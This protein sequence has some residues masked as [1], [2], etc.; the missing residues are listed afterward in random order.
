MQYQHAYHLEDGR[1]EFIPFTVPRLGKFD[2]SEF[3]EFP[4]R[5]GWCVHRLDRH[6]HKSRC[7]PGVCVAVNTGQPHCYG[8]NTPSISRVGG[9]NATCSMKLA[10][11][12]TWLFFGALAEAHAVCNLPIIP[13]DFSADVFDTARRNGLPMRLYF[14]SKESGHAGSRALKEKLYAIIRQIQLMITRA[15]DWEDEHDYTL[16]Q[17][18][19]L[20][21]IQIL[22]RM[23][24]LALLCHS[25]SPFLDLEDD[26]SLSVADPVADW[27]PEGQMSMMK[28]TANRLLEKGWCRSELWQILQSFDVSTAAYYLDRPYAIQGHDSCTDT[29]CTAYQ[30]NESSYSTLHIDSSCS[31]AFIS[32]KPAELRD[33][34]A[35]NAIPKIAITDDLQLSIVDED[36]L[37]YIAFSH[38]W[39]DGLGNPSQNALPSCH[40]R[41]LRDLAVDLCSKFELVEKRK[42]MRVAIWM[43]TLC[44]PVAPEL[45]EY[46]KLAIRLLAQT[47]AEA[48]GVLV[49]DR[50]LCRFES[51]NASILELSIRL[52]CSGWLKR[53][54]TLQEASLTGQEAANERPGGALYIQMAEG[55]AHWHGHAKRFMYKPFSTSRPTPRKPSPLAVSV[56]EA[57]TDLVYGMHL[58]TAMEDRLPSVRTIQEPRFDTR[59]QKI[60][61]AVQNRSTSKPEDEPICMASLLALDLKQILSAKGVDERMMKFYRLLHEIPTAIVFAEFGLPDF[62]SRNIT[63][64]PYRWA[65]RSLLSL[66]RPMEINIALSAMRFAD[67]PLPLL[68]KCEDDGLHI[69]HPGFLFED[70]GPVTFARETALLDTGE[71]SLYRLSLAL[72]DSSPLTIGPVERC[73][74]IFKTDICSDVA[75]VALESERVLEAGM[76]FCVA[77]L[78]HGTVT[79]QSASELSGRDGSTGLQALRG[80]STKRDQQWCIT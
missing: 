52:M 19:V 72:S 32:V 15:S 39:A 60:V 23:L 51:G 71:G 34:L 28:F 70:M 49:I 73:A 77:I 37:V 8:L 17:C 9:G 6:C 26:L 10:F 74:L 27:K 20:F 40:I 11:L 29:T 50:E 21:S 64:A 55:P 13:D 75:I 54:W 47:Y 16:T 62:L 35:R 59:F 14:A 25:R 56:Q 68:G 24:S 57:K 5:A 45:K 1:P 18:E 78:G 33:V 2:F 30:I 80:C 66:D 41:R 38:V 58:L 4:A 48:R 65:P 44:I 53:L 42:P 69:E 7:P 76:C 31:C 12:Q 79:P 61:A 36:G 67:P 22:L 46:R 3:W 63:S 43:D